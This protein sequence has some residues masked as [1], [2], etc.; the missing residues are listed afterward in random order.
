MTTRFNNR[1]IINRNTARIAELST[2]RPCNL[3]KDE[4]ASL[5]HAYPYLEKLDMEIVQEIG[6]KAVCRVTANEP[7]HITHR[8]S[9]T[10][11]RYR[12]NELVGAEYTFN[13]NVLVTF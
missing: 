10:T 8:A 9:G 13:K 7:F 3:H 6:D 5:R 11:I 4:I 2:G 1:I 12:K